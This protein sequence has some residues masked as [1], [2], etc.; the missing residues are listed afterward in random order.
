MP[1]GARRRVIQNLLLS[2]TTGAVATGVALL[3]V[4]YYMNATAGPYG[5]EGVANSMLIY[6]PL[7]LLIGILLTATMSTSLTVRELSSFSTRQV[8]AVCIAV[9]ITSA[10]LILIELWLAGAAWFIVNVNLLHLPG[11]PYK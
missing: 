7:T 4:S 8:I 3:L 6:A 10:A 1:L 2:S 5:A 9:W 11:T